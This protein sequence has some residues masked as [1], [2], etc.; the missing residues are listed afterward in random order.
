MKPMRKQDILSVLL[1]LMMTA[2]LFLAA[3]TMAGAFPRQD[4]EGYRAA[5]SL[6]GKN[7][8]SP[9]LTAEF[10]KASGRA[11]YLP[12]M[13]R[14]PPWTIVLIL[15]LK[16]LSYPVAFAFL[17]LLN[18][19]L[20]AGCARA[21]WN[22]QSTQPSI[23]PA[24]LSL[25]FGPTVVLLMLGQLTAL[26]LLGVLLFLALVRQRS[27]WLAGA[28]LLLLMPKP[29]LVLYFLAAVGFWAIRE[30]RWAVL[31]GGAL[32]FGAAC[33]GALAINPHIFAQYL[34]FARSFF[35]ETELYPN[36]G[37]ILRATTHVRLLSW[38]PEISG[39][40]WLGYFWWK[41]R[42]HWDW[43][44]QGLLTLMVSV[45]CSYHS[46]PYDEIL[47]LPG[48]IAA[49][50]HGNRTVFWTGF[51]AVNSGYLLY[52]SGTAG[53]LGYGHLFLWWTASGWLAT[54]LLS[55]RG[56]ATAEAAS[57]SKWQ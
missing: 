44:R 35:H 32:A 31:I 54:Y 39:A 34:A 52:I 28:A 15:P 14:N 4:L 48:L 38:L 2:M 41:H 46:F 10:E 57:A 42:D 13:M 40:L 50:V 43:R 6:A 3:V 29:H 47:F 12:P 21:A 55:M 8:Y 16:Y 25:I 37:A 1:L 20:V 11:G 36:L 22:L 53:R 30:K 23:V 19:M 26:V 51:A 33:A 7:P 24:F 27:D 17:A 18:V 45:V 5:A 49:Y 9:A 56:S